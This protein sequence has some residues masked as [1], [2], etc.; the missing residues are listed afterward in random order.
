MELKYKRTYL[1]PNVKSKF[2]LYKNFGE[3]SVIKKP[4]TLNAKLL[5]I[6]EFALSKEASDPASTGILPQQ[7]VPTQQPEQPYQKGRDP[8]TV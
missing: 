8:S 4:K 6:Q 1:C 3:I 2:R 7:A 5:T